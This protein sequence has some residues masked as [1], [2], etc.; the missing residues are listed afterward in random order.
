MEQNPNSNS[1]PNKYNSPNLAI[2]FLSTTG[3]ILLVGLLSIPAQPTT[4]LADGMTIIKGEYVITVGAITKNDEELV[5]LIDTGA[6]KL[7][8]YRF[9]NA[10]KQIELIQSIPLEEMRKQATG[11][12]DD[13]KQKPKGGKKP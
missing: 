10:K 1:N 7:N 3:V 6:Q 5:Y 12:P 2:G 8:T 11:T 9:D 13:Q 4:T